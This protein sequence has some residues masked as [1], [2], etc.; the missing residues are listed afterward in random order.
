MD[1]HE[2][3]SVSLSWC[4]WLLVKN[5]AVQDELR[6][7]VRTLFGDNDDTPTYEQINALPF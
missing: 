1:R 4:L 5:Q 7:E 3:T 2:T 6:A